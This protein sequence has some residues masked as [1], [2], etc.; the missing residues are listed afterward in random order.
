MVQKAAQKSGVKTGA[1][2]QVRKNSGIKS[3]TE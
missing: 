1:Q 3:C 2:K